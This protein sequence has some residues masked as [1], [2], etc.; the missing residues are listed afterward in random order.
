[1]SEQCQIHPWTNII[2]NEVC[3]YCRME[4]LKAYTIAVLSTAKTIPL[5]KVHEYL[6]KKI[7]EYEKDL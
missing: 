2:E 5:D 3:P 4:E 1:M 6:E 7:K